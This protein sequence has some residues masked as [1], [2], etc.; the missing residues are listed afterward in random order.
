MEEDEAVYLSTYRILYESAFAWVVYIGFCSTVF[1]LNHSLLAKGG[2]RTTPSPLNRLNGFRFRLI[3]IVSI[4]HWELEPLYPW[5]S[6][7]KQSGWSLVFGMIHGARIPGP[8][9][10]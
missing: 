8:T 7:N 2:R 1:P 9:K 3:C 6:K 4:Q 10:G 5:K